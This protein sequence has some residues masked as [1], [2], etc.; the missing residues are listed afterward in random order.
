MNDKYLLT[1]WLQSSDYNVSM[2]RQV[3]AWLAE[4]APQ[5]FM[6]LWQMSLTENTFSIWNDI[7]DF[8]MLKEVFVS[9][10]IKIAKAFVHI[11]NVIYQ[12]VNNNALLAGSLSAENLLTLLML[13]YVNEC[14]LVGKCLTNFKDI[15]GFVIS[16]LKRI[17]LCKVVLQV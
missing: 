12:W 16:C 2:K 9:V 4:N 7:V 6:S 8:Q 3:L 14:L 10:D 5:T 15:A 1:E 17:S 13:Q 11:G